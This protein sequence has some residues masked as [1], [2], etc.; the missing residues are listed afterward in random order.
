LSKGL[1][2]LPEYLHRALELS[3]LLDDKRSRAIINLHLGRLHWFT[4]HSPELSKY[5][6]EGIKGV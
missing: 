5:I 6:T 2:D 4:D 1:F 3:D